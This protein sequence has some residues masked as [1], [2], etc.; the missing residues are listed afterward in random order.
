VYMIYTDSSCQPWHP[1]GILTWAFLVKHK[2]QL[3]H[4][5]AKIIGWGKEDLTVNRGEMTAV[6]AAMLWLIRLPKE[7]RIPAVINS[8]SQLVV[9]QCS[10]SWGCH[11]PNLKAILDL[12]FKAKGRYRKSI[13]YKWIPR[14]KNKEADALSRTPYN[15]RMLAL[16]RAN[17][18]NIIHNWDD[19]PW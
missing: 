2:K 4:Q 7:E 9:N 13:I 8:D 1:G 15:E 19:L 16:M 5:E 14:E 6:L 10:E 12:I 18:N 3:I 11:E 17:K